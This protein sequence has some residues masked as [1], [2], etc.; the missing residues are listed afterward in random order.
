MRKDAELESLRSEARQIEGRIEDLSSTL[1]DLDA[2]ISERSLVLVQAALEHPPEEITFGYHEC[3]QSPTGECAYDVEEDPCEDS[4]LF[5][6][7]PS[8]RK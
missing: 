6:E 5:C 3:Q 4:C 8:E 1:D 7:Q 2:Q